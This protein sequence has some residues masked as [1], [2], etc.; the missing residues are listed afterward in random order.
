MWTIGERL[1]RQVHK[2]Q[3]SVDKSGRKQERNAEK[4]IQKQKKPQ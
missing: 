1:S 2:K 4:R 3:K